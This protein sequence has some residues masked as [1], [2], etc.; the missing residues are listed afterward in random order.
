MLRKFFMAVP[1]TLLVVGGTTACATKKFVRTSVGEV[2]GK[3]DS[4]GRSVEETQER[5]RR[6]EGKISEVDQKAEAAAQ[7]ATQANQAAVPRPPRM[8]RVSRQQGR[9]E[10]RAMT[11]ASRRL[12]RSRAQRRSGQL[13]VRSDQA[14]DEAKMKI[15]EMV[16]Q[17]KQDPKNV[18]IEIEGHTDNVGDKVINEKIGLARAEAVQR[19]L[20]EQYQIPLHK[21]SV[22]SYGQEK[23]AAPNKTR[24]GRAQNRRVVRNVLD[25]PKE[26]VKAEGQ[27]EPP[28]LLPLPLPFTFFD[29]PAPSSPSC[30][31]PSDTL[32]PMS[33]NVEVNLRLPNSPGA[34]ASVCRL[35]S[36]ERVNITAMA[37]DATGQLR[38][39]LDNHVHGAAVLRDHHHQ[40]AERD[41]IVTSI[42]NAPGSLA[43]V[44][45]LVAD[46]NV[47]VD[48]AYGGAAAG[49]PM[50]TLVLGVEDAARAS[51]A[52][53]V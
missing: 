23:P 28:L 7:S 34:L 46:A 26:E 30:C 13:Q 1:V 52:A 16:Q 15:D 5:T 35:L 2:N 53:G 37:L 44:L 17:L 50:A 45:R 6:N 48:Y 20:Y 31:R 8:R 40:V 32:S 14:S 36:D 43:P 4:L 49:S 42:P 18:F 3:V 21:M 39:V 38:L 24:A 25:R 33:V 11:P 9:R 29:S 27:I 22:I 19:Y 51:A 10:G 12:V 47:N 41:V